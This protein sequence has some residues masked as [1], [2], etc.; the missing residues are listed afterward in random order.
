MAERRV[1]A[2]RGSARIGSRMA[3]KERIE[4]R[5]QHASSHVGD[6]PANV[7]VHQQGEQATR[8][9]ITEMPPAGFSQQLNFAPGRS[10]PISGQQPSSFSVSFPRWR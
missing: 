1:P 3:F 4:G 6:A 7:G 8:A 10:L 9:R 2:E 5:Q